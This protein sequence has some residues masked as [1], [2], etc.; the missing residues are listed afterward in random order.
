MVGGYNDLKD[1]FEEPV[2]ET[3]EELDALCREEARRYL[4]DAKEDIAKEMGPCFDI[5]SHPEFITAYMNLRAQRFNTLLLVKTLQEGFSSICA[6]V[7]AWWE[8][9]RDLLKNLSES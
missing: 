4:K 8:N 6:E 7:D 9:L 3:R 1:F 2:V 5:S